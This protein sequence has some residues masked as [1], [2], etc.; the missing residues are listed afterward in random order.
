[1][2]AC[3]DAGRSLF[4][5]ID[6]ELEILDS[7]YRIPFSNISS[8]NSP[9]RQTHRFITRGAYLPGEVPGTGEIVT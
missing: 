4:Q 5:L 2:A 8:S 1:M 7:L 3:W 9:G 6:V